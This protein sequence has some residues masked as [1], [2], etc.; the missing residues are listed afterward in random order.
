MTYRQRGYEPTLSMMDSCLSV[1][2][3]WGIVFGTIVGIQFWA[4]GCAVTW[5][6]GG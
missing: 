5:C 6:I 3:F 1:I 4:T 2:L